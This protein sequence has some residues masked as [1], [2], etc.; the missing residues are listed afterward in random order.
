M[1]A[2]RKI[3]PA[4]VLT[5]IEHA[6]WPVYEVFFRTRYGHAPDRGVHSD[7][8]EFRRSFVNLSV[9]QAAPLP[10]RVGHAGQGELTTVSARVRP[11]LYSFVFTEALQLDWPWIIAVRTHVLPDSLLP[12]PMLTLLASLRESAHHLGYTKSVD[13]KITPVLKRLYLHFGATALQ[14]LSD[15]HLIRF[16]TALET[17]RTSPDFELYFASEQDWQ[18]TNHGFHSAMFALRVLLYHRG[19]LAALPKK[20]PKRAP[21]PA[22]TQPTLQLLERYCE[23]RTAQRAAPNT[24]AKYRYAVKR[25]LQWLSEAYPAVQSFDQVQ[26]DHALAYSTFLDTTLSSRTHQP[27]SLE[28]KI[29]RLSDLSVFLQD[30]SA[31]GWEGAPRRPLLGPRDLPK[32]PRSIPRYIPDDQLQRLMPEIHALTCPFQRAA[33]LIAR[34][35]GARRG[36]IQTLDLDCLDTYPDGTPRLRL[37][38][39]KSRTERV[40]PLHP[41]AAAAIRQLQENAH[42]LR[43][44]R[45]PTTGIESKRLFVRKG[46]ILHVNYLVEAPLLQICQKLGLL[47][48]NGNALITAHRFRHTVGTQLAEG[49]ARLHTI[50]KMLGHTSTEMTLVYA[51][52]S[53]RA[54]VEDYQRV[55]GP[56]SVIAGGSI[57]KQLQAG[58][59]PE[60]SI[61]WLKTNF[62]KTELELGHCLRLPQ[63]GPCE[64]DLYLNC[65]KFVTTATYA[66]RL[67]ARRLRELELIAD[68]RARGWPREVE[69]HECALRL[70]EDYLSALDE[71]VKLTDDQPL[72]D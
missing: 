42:D 71:P 4:A 68:A 14:Q 3:E 72:E 60:A 50:M 63:E 26:R 67:R 12:A 49:G 38:V 64:C 36:E 13:R 15:E 10:V 47:H 52:I 37:P 62:F 1:T 41:E 31:W 27:I 30:V 21:I 6:E 40:V 70:L 53:D 29:S 51:H 33:L 20:R 19:T 25:F 11:Y 65:A 45:H 28:T 32:R 43:G 23:A 48:P 61:E 18:A 66:P 8:Q 39:G 34:W 57:A 17:F 54:V 7:Y 35:S 69:R 24:I 56:G 44:F 5:V 16:E 22:P 55:L 9:W 46:R 59:L 2:I 58:T